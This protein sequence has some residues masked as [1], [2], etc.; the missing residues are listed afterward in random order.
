MP[1]FLYI[2]NH[3]HI[4]YNEADKEESSMK[5]KMTAAILM[6]DYKKRIRPQT[7]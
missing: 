5:K 2:D 4:G 7:L 1:P 6:F 3:H